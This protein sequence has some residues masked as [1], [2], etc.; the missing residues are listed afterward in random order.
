ML[1]Y[2]Q[3]TSSA[4]LIKLVRDVDFAADYEEKDSQCLCDLRLTDP[5][6]DKIRIERTKDDLLKDSY[7]WI[8]YHQDFI[9]WR[10]G[11][12][13]QLLWIKGDPS[14]GKTMLLICIIKELLQQLKSTYNSDLQG[15]QW[16]V[17]SI[18]N[19]K[20]VSTKVPSGFQFH[21]LI[22]Q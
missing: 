7:T 12:K 1:A 5:R 9:N 3:A 14:K 15:R 17:F 21:W 2:Y 8:L 6:D 20:R 22:T 18:N 11:D 4:D 13:T 19:P 10:N 16:R